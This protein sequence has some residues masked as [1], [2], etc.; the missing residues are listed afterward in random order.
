MAIDHDFHVP[1]DELE[2]YA[3]VQDFGKDGFF[4]FNRGFHPLIVVAPAPKSFNFATDF[5]YPF[6]PEIDEQLRALGQIDQEASIDVSKK[7]GRQLKS[8]S[9]KSLEEKRKADRERQRKCRAK[10]K[11]LI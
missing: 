9:N 7:R 10:K 8:V 4:I 6:Q 11:G 2:P 3:L 1:I 5:G